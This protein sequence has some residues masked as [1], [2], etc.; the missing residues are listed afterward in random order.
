MYS[1]YQFLIRYMTC[2]FFPFCQSSFHL[3][4]DTICSKKIN[5]QKH[6]NIAIL[7]H[8]ADFLFNCLVA[9]FAANTHTKKHTTIAI[10]I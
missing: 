8:P 5:K 2:N 4:D 9:L 6:T 7:S 10:L 1:R 3:F